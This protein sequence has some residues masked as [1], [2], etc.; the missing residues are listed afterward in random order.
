L[1]KEDILLEW[2]FLTHEGDGGELY[3]GRSYSSPSS[4]IASRSWRSSMAGSSCPHLM[5]RRSS[6]LST[7]SFSKSSYVSSK[8]YADGMTSWVTS[9]GILSQ[10]LLPRGTFPPGQR[11]VPITHAL[12]ISCPGKARGQDVD[13]TIPV[14]RLGTGAHRVSSISA[15]AIDHQEMCVGD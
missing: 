2:T 5:S 7:L 3:S 15:L 10:A 4:F 11:G 9:P 1:A 6:W 12:V 14:A 8:S 13:W